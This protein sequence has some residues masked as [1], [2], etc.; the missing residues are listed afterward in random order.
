MW[1]SLRWLLWL[2]S[3]GLGRPAF[4]VAARGL[5]VEA[6]GLSSTGS[7]VVAQGL[8][9]PEA[10]GIFPDQGTHV[11]CIGRQ[12]PCHRATR[13]GRGLGFKME[14]VPGAVGQLV[15]LTGLSSFLCF[16]CSP[17]GTQD[18]PINKLL[19]ARDIPRYK[20]MVERYEGRELGLED[21][22]WMDGWVFTAEAPGVGLGG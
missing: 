3:T 4:I 6:P 22:Q 21:N 11:S 20:R 1:A 8:S 18:S 7:G 5:I 10:C 16:G 14:A 17:A 13:E 12:S 9:C 2:R 19:Y 15:T